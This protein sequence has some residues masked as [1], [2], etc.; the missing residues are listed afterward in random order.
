MADSIYKLRLARS[1]EANVF[2]PRGTLEDIQTCLATLFTT[3]KY[4]V[5]LY[6]DFGFDMEALDQPTPRGMALLRG[7]IYD[8][9]GEYEPRAEIVSVTF[10]QAEQYADDRVIPVISWRLKDGVEL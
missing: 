4:T 10:E 7:E 1:G 8:A 9:A 6:R 2:A 5:P 3:R